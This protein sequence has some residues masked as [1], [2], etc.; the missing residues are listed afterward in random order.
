MFMRQN[1][2]DEKVPDYLWVLEKHEDGAY[3]FNFNI[4]TVDDEFAI[5]NYEPHLPGQHIPKS[6]PPPLRSSCKNGFF[7]T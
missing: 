6:W 4:P 2:E 5:V 3:C 1:I 7:A